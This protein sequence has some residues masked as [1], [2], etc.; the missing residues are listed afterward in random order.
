M[1]D[2]IIAGDDPSA[3]QTLKDDLRSLFNIKDLD[4]LK[5]FLG[6]EAS[7]STQGIHIS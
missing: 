3:I 1:D 2:I 6:I 5:Y 7:H 4:H